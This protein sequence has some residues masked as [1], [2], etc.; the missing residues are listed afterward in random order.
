MKTQDI[1]TSHV[2]TITPTES[3]KDAAVKMR[4][5]HIGALLVVDG[6]KLV[7]MIT[8]RDICCKV[9]AT[10]RDAVMTQVG[11]IMAKDI[12]TCFEDQEIT[13]AAKIM[14]DRH[15]RRLPVVHHDKSLAGM[16][17]VDDL[18]RTSHDLA[19]TVLEAVGPVH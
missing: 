4:N 6:G 17:S 9:I 8:D 3:T 19:G 14:A 12:T 11:E 15:V 18:A 13:D 5:L 2:E 16:L 10:G 7:G 1:M